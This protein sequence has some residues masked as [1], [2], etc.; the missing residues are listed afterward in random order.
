MTTK[1]RAVSDG[2]Y[3]FIEELI[4]IGPDDRGDIRELAMA[5]GAIN[6]DQVLR[7][8]RRLIILARARSEIGSEG[9]DAGS[10]SYWTQVAVGIA[11]AIEAV[12]NG[13]RVCAEEAISIGYAAGLASAQLQDRVIEQ[14]SH[15]KTIA[16]AA[17]AGVERS[18]ALARG[19]AGASKSRTAWE[20][21][22]IQWVCDRRT[23][24]PWI[25]RD[26]LAREMAPLF[27]REP[28]TLMRK[29]SE[30]LKAG[31]IPPRQ[32]KSVTSACAMNSP[33][34]DPD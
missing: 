20:K 18:R 12:L 19:A 16:D 3:D 31:L 15:G 34:S 8:L 26:L 22:A 29:L 6:P 25:S 7:D 9:T 1:T 4:V 2:A 33:Q 28:E 13:R 27:K 11:D 30:W 10:T 32:K 24:Q 5:M 14:P 21:A 23:A 17:H